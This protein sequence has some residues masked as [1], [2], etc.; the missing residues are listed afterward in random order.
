MER[1]LTDQ[2]IPLDREA[3]AKIFDLH[4]DELYRY[5]YGRLGHQETAED[6]TQAAFHRLVEAIGRGRGPSRNAR[7]WL[8]RVARNLAVDE[9][10]RQTLRSRHAVRDSIEAAVGVGEQAEA[11]IAAEGLRKAMDHL[12]RRQREVIE[13]KFVHGLTTPEVAEVLTLSKRGVLKLQ[14]RGLAALRTQLML[15]NVREGQ[16]R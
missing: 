14:Q 2:P 16:T 9:V 4:Y 7:A 8:Y 3:V 1:A 15:A 12:T 5:L 13:L 6:L 10:R 11:N